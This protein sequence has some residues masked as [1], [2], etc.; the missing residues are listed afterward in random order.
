[1]EIE[2]GIIHEDKQKDYWNLKAHKGS[3]GSAIGGDIRDVEDDR[4]QRRVRL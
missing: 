4:R 2:L 1:M 3:A